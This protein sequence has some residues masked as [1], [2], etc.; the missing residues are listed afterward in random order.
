[1]R[2]IEYV[3][4]SNGARKG[5]RQS[6][7][8]QT[9]IF[10]KHCLLYEIEFGEAESHGSIKHGAKSGGS[11]GVHRALL[12]DTRELLRMAESNVPLSSM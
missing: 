12:W 11:I 7:R 6:R 4:A 10:M 2:R 8:S 9:P 5:C 1:M 3:A